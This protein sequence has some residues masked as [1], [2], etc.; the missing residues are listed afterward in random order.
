MGISNL[1]SAIVRVGEVSSTDPAKATVRVKFPDLDGLISYDYQ[2]VSMFTERNKDYRMPDIGD[3]V[4]CLCMGNGLE[5]GFAIGSVYSD[6]VP[7]PVED[8]DKR[9]VRYPDGTWFE[10]DRAEHKL[11]VH[12]E[13]GIDVYAKGDI[14]VKA[15]GKIVIAATDNVVVN[16][17]QVRWNEDK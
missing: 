9:H 7:P 11:T 2:V 6:K 13:G 15:D 12:V 4:V 1:G 17:A 8:Q 10:Y 14:A 16:G 5:T 3:E